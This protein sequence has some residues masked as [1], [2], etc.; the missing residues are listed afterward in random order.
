MAPAQVE[1]EVYLDAEAGLASAPS[2][3]RAGLLGS[4]KRLPSKYFYD[5]RGSELFE[6]ITRLDE[7]YPTRPRRPAGVSV[8]KHYQH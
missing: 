5:E 8:A 7:Y 6:E 1:I 3:I 2:D 4:P